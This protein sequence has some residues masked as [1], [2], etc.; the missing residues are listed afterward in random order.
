MLQSTMSEKIVYTK[1]LKNFYGFATSKNAS[2]TSRGPSLPLCILFYVC[3]SSGV[4]L[5][6]GCLSKFFDNPPNNKV[7][8]ILCGC[9]LGG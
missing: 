4:L 3:D 9:G 1:F 8:Y 5:G 7:Y 2:L 6:C